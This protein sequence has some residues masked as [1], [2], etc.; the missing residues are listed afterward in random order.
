MPL[1]F[2]LGVTGMALRLKAMLLRKR[3]RLPLL[4]GRRLLRREG[5]GAGLTRFAH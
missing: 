2:L 3:P 1:G 4:C 5:L